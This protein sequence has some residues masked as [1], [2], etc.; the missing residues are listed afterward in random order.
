MTH[1]PPY[2]VP[3]LCAQKKRDTMKMASTCLLILVMTFITLVPGG[4]IE[5]RDFSH[6]GGPVFWGFN[7]FLISLGLIAIA[8]AV[9][10]RFG[11]NLA[12]WIAIGV[13]WGYIFVVAL[14]LGHVFPLSPDP[15]PLLLGIIEILDGILAAYVMVLCHR[16]LGHI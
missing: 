14:D 13:S 12:A 4:P 7:A 1:E 16:A 2:D 3:H 11:Y 5:T 10:L 6:L 8:S 15:I 9:M